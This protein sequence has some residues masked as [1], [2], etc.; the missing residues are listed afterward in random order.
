MDTFDNTVQCKYMN[1][2]T[3]SINRLNTKKKRTIIKYLLRNK[4][5][6]CDSKIFV[7]KSMRVYN[8]FQK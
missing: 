2:F 4:L 6:L 1:S 7:S 3:V 8:K 5:L